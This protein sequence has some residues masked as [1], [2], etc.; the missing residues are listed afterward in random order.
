MAQYRTFIVTDIENPKE[1]SMS[2][3][4]Y[5]TVR[6]K[7]FQEEQGIPYTLDR[8]G[9]D[10][11]IHTFHIAAYVANAT[12]EIVGGLRL[13]FGSRDGIFKLERMA[14]LRNHRRKRVGESLMKAA[15]AFARYRGMNKIVLN[16]QVS[17]R[18]FYEHSGYRS[19]G[20]LFREAGIEH[21]SMEKSI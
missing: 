8:D 7:V 1:Y 6:E 18:A 2:M 13:R 16:A 15:E 21:I 3:S 5:M 9:Y 17:A 11:D 12:R 10:Y 19:T 20:R 14:V 4:Q